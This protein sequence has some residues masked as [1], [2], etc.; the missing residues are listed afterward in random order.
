MKKLCN[1]FILGLLLVTIFIVTAFSF[2][3]LISPAAYLYSNGTNY[4]IIF[5]YNYT[6]TI[7]TNNFNCTLFIDGINSGYNKSAS[8]NATSPTAASLFIN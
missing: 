7:G 6:G 8:V 1:K 3:R 4:S 2:V 5:K